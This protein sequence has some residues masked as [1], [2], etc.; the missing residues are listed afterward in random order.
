MPVDLVVGGSDGSQALPSAPS[1]VP[2]CSVSKHC[3]ILMLA[4]LDITDGRQILDAIE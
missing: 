3:S 4:N 1:L 2:I